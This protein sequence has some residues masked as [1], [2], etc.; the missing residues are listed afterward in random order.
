MV[1]HHY[2]KNVNVAHYAKDV[3]GGPFAKNVNGGSFAKNVKGVRGGGSLSQNPSVF[4][5]RFY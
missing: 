1:A 2:A 4:Y 5:F 3:N